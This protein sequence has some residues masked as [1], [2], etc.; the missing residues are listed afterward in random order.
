MGGPCRPS[1][2]DAEPEED[3]AQGMSRHGHPVKPV[4]HMAFMDVPE[5]MAGTTS[6]WVGVHA[7]SKLVQRDLKADRVGDLE[8]DSGSLLNCT[9]AKCEKALAP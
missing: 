7:R 5:A 8:S 2:G 6:D 1:Q 4:I 3:M 9:G